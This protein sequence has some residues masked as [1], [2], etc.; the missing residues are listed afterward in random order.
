MP[1]NCLH[2]FTSSLLKGNELT[3]FWLFCFPHFFSTQLC[4]PLKFKPVFVAKMVCSL[5]PS[6]FCVRSWQ[7]N[8]LNFSLIFS[9]K[10]VAPCPG[11]KL[12]GGT[13]SATYNVVLNRYL[14]PS[15]SC[16]IFI[17]DYFCVPVCSLN[18]VLCPRS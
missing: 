6:L 9:L 8:E 16:K 17:Y 12:K 5:S 11:Y 15:F 7:I 1:L 2:C 14:F 4:S 13:R 10:M 3:R 18:N